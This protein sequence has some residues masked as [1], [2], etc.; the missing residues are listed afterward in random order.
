MKEISFITGFAR[1]GPDLKTRNSPGNNQLP[2]YFRL[3]SGYE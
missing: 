2:S 3:L 1:T